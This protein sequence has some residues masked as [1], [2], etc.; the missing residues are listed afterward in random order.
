M[1][2]RYT[3]GFAYSAQ[4]SSIYD[5]IIDMELGEFD[6]HKYSILIDKIKQIKELENDAYNMLSLEDVER[7]LINIDEEEIDSDRA[8][9]RY[10]FKLSE[11]RKILIGDDIYNEKYLISDVIN[12]VILINSL[13]KLNEK[14]IHIS[15]QNFN[16]IDEN[17]IANSLLFFYNTSKYTFLSSSSFIEDLMLSYGFNLWKM[18]KIN[19]YNILKDYDVDLTIQ[20]VSAMKA[21]QYMKKISDCDDE[22]E[23]DIEKLYIMLLNM[24]HFEVLISYLDKHRLAYII[25]E[26]N[27]SNFK[28]NKNNVSS[29]RKIL[30]KRKEELSSF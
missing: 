8:I 28:K 21:I 14:I 25:R 20:T 2:N 3:K 12:S 23:I 30:I 11:R 16:S 10:Y 1:F 5:E 13:E 4:I 7:Y 29:V 15:N 24:T 22:E 18:P 26:F 19:L 17:V 9:E 6:F 27:A